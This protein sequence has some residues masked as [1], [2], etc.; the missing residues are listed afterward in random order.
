MAV[1]NR[2][3]PL[4][5]KAILEDYPQTLADHRVAQARVYSSVERFTIAV[6]DEA[7]STYTVGRLPREAVLTHG[8]RVRIGAVAV[9]GTFDLGDAEEDDALLDGVAGAANTT[10]AFS[11]G[12]GG[13]ATVADAGKPI[14]QLLGYSTVADAPREID[15]IVTL[16]GSTQATNPAE[17]VV[18]LE[19]TF[20]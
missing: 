2:N 19:Y 18:Y 7:T 11:P 15:L 20:T 16:R 10:Y 13:E 12:L 8:C 4:Y 14:W 1:V 5:M 6:G 17:G 9:T 3:G